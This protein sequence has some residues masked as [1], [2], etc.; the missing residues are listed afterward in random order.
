MPV[1]LQIVLCV[2]AAD[3]ITGL[4][5]WFEDTY[6]LPDWPLI[7]PAVIEPNMRH[8]EN[9]TIFVTMSTLCLRNYQPVTLAIAACG[10]AWACG[11]LCWQ[12]M[13]VS[14]LA[15]CGNEVHGWAHVRPKSSLARLL[16]SM[17]I[18]QTPQQHAK[19]H[20]PPYAGWFCSLTN[21]VNPL[22]EALQFWPRL[23]W[24]IGFTTGVWPKRM[25]AAR[26]GV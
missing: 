25:T 20:R 3:F 4:V 22:L 9:P 18:V 8:H 16:Q 14:A 1:S 24:A 23:E 11:L 6:G 19:H 21:I 2:L 10:L 12:M 17:C 5:H 13:V 15:A 7:G 26:R